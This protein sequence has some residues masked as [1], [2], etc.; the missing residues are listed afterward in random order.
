MMRWPGWFLAIT[1]DQPSAADERGAI[2]RRSRYGLMSLR[3]ASSALPMTAT[4]TAT[5]ATRI[6]V[7]TV[8]LL[9]AVEPVQLALTRRM[10]RKLHP[11]PR[12]RL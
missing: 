12:R 6:V 7:N 10:P 11:M 5:T 2:V 8:G 3:G 9:L 4:S 1:A